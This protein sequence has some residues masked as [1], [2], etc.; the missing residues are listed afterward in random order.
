M[1]TRQ[2]VFGLVGIIAL[3]IAFEV[4]R[5]WNL[6]METLTLNPKDR[7]VTISASPQPDT[8]KCE[9]DYPVVFLRQQNHVQWA[10]SD[11]KYWV[12]FLTIDAPPGY[13]PENP[14]V[15]TDDPV[16]V[17]PNHPSKLYNVKL[18]TKYYMYAIFDHDPTADPKNPCK[19]AVDDH[20]PGLN[21][22][23]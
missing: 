13:T 8:G 20:D 10:S 14:L 3:V 18:A 1:K 23:P 6:Q 21:V 7:H 15:P 16:V 9:V 12:S 4:G 19:A 5:R 11:K 2:V 22:K 17:D